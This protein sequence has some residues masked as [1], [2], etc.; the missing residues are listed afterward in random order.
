MWNGVATLQNS[1]SKKL[2]MELPYDP[3]TPLLG[4]YPRELKKKI[5]PHKKHAQ[6]SS[7]Q[8]T[9]KKWKGISTY[10]W[11][12]KMQSIRTVDQYSA[13]KS[14]EVLIYTTA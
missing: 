3:P 1:S 9:A 12:N 2:N 11:M 6:E 10:W 7:E 8:Q 14:D 13:I 5:C 4:I